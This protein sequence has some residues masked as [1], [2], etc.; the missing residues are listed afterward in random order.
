M[1]R[2]GTS[3]DGTQLGSERSEGLRCSRLI[4]L[5]TASSRPITMIATV[6]MIFDLEKRS[7]V[8]STFLTHRAACFEAAN[9]PIRSGGR[10]LSSIRP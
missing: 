5:G 6:A 2:D 7:I 4:M 10:P 1:A 8:S 3:Q 9:R